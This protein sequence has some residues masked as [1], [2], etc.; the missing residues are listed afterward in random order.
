MIAIKPYNHRYSGSYH[1]SLV[2]LLLL[3][4][5]LCTSFQVHGATRRQCNNNLTL[6]EVQSLHF[7]DMVA[8]PTVAGTVTISAISGARTS[9][10]GVVLAGG[11]VSRGAYDL[12]VNITGCD[13]YYYRIR[14]PNSASITNGAGTMTVNNFSSDPPRSDAGNTGLLQ[15]VPV[16]IYVG[17][18]LAVGAA[19]SSGA[20]TGPF[21]VIV[22]MRNS[23]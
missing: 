12:T 3:M 6:T 14:L 20:Y 13:T 19:Q 1:H 15:G 22:N 23:P 4:I 11:T 8:S 2:A 21:N 9:N 18:D 10:G 17:G 7:G 5:F 16:R